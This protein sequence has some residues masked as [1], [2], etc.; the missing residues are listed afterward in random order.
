MTKPLTDIVC[1]PGW[2]YRASVFEVLR[3]HFPHHRLHFVNL[4]Q[5]N[6]C[7][8]LSTLANTLPPHAAL[9]GWSMG[10]LAA[11]ALCAQFPDLFPTLILLSSTPRFIADNEWQGIN[12]ENAASFMQQTMLDIQKTLDQFQALTCFPSRAA[13]AYFTLHAYDAA[14]PSLADELHYLFQVDLRRQFVAL[15]QPVLSIHGARDAVLS[16]ALENSHIL[17]DAGHAALFTHAEEVSRL[18]H[19][20]IGLPT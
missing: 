9:I 11:I 6:D 7:M 19:S 18:I 17:P 8:N 4:P 12:S 10:G 2:S 14:H 1:L 20:H 3:P 13:R 16:P 5:L 15:T